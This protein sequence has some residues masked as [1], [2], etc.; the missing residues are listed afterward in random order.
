MRRR[1]NWRIYYWL[2]RRGSGIACI[3]VAAEFF[4]VCM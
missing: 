4:R 2:R 3:G 1:Y